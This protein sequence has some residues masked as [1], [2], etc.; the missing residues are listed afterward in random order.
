MADFRVNRPPRRPRPSLGQ[1]GLARLGLGQL[2][3]TGA[4]LVHLGPNGR[5]YPEGGVDIDG[6]GEGRGAGNALTGPVRQVV[7]ALYTLCK[8]SLYTTGRPVPYM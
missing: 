6:I 4:S 8:S 5:F 7:I 3:S 1:L 2:G